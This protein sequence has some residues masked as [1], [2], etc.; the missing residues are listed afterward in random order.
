MKNRKRFLYS[1]LALLVFGLCI[2]FT[3]PVKTFADGETP[4]PEVTAEPVVTTGQEV[5]TNPT[6]E[7]KNGWIKEKG[8]TYHYK[9]GEKLT[10]L[11]K[12]NK[13]LYYFDKS[14]KRVDNKRGIRIGKYY[15]KINSK[16]VAVKVS[17][18]EGLAGI[19]VDRLA[20]KTTDK[21]AIL[22]KA[23]NWSAKLKYGLKGLK[24][25]TKNQ[26]EYYGAFGFKNNYGD[27]YVQAAT[28]YWMA[29]SIGFSGM[30]FVQGY[31]PS[32]TGVKQPHG[33][34]ERKV[35]TKYYFFDPNAAGEKKA[36]TTYNFLY[37]T[38]GSF[39]YNDS[40]QHKVQYKK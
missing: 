9:N 15:Y 27:C 3:A 34:V 12:I 35:G 14:G 24:K 16:G 17:E 36:K 22:K 29:K 13:K 19:Q 6:E 37:G 39:A 11:Q 33:W 38:P 28:F 32:T 8:A 23:F 20:G 30:K 26:A 4:A 25:A 18:A 2:G 40:H 5:T 21:N 31:V 1:L 7:V 10:G